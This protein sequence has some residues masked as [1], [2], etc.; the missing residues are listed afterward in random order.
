MMHADRFHQVSQK[1]LVVYED[2]VFINQANFISI[3]TAQLEI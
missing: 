2:G 3:G 1:H